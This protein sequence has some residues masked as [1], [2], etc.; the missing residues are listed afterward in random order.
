MK[1][2]TFLFFLIAALAG[3][4]QTIELLGVSSRPDTVICQG[5]TIS[6]I[7]FREELLL[8]ENGTEYPDTVEQKTLF[9]NG[10]CPADSTEVARQLE[11]EARNIQARRAGVMSNA[12]S[13]VRRGQA[14]FQEVRT[15]FNAFTSSDLYLELEDA[16][17]NNFEGRY[18]IFDV[19]AGTSVQADMIRIGATERYRL[20]VIPG[21]VGAGTRYTV[22]PLHPTAFQINA[23]TP[24]GGVA[25]NYYMCQ[26]RDADNINPI[27]RENGFLEGGTEDQLRIVKIR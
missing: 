18:R 9:R 24:S 16:F 2:I 12:F 10:A 15:V 4:A 7:Y 5:D 22:L 23:W 13:A 20:K 27:Y 21:E 25:A 1:K 26:D 6:P 3:Q 17:W 8:V 11:V 14:D 19:Q